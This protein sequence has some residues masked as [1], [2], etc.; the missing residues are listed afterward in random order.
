[1]QSISWLFVRCEQLVCF[2]ICEG[3]LIWYGIK[4]NRQGWMRW[5]PAAAGLLLC[6]VVIT[7]EF[8]LD[9]KISL[10]DGDIPSGL[11]YGIVGLFLAWTA[12]EEHRGHQAL[13]TERGA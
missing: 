4:T 3:I 6:L 12:R 13:P 10:P 2:L 5:R 11:I 7:G 9:G 8:A 1:M